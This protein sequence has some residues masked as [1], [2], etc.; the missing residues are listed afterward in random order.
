MEELKFVSTD[1]VGDNVALL[2]RGNKFKFIK[3]VAIIL[4]IEAALLFSL[5]NMEK[6][7]KNIIIISILML[8]GV[9]V[10]VLMKKMLKTS[11]G[12]V[13]KHEVREYVSFSFFSDKIVGETK[14]KD[15]GEV[16]SK[17]YDY[18]LVRSFKEDATRIYLKVS[19]TAFLVVNK[20]N[21]DS[22]DIEK[23]KNLLR[24]KGI[25]VD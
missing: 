20:S 2:R 18:R 19:D 10:V 17:D 23:L 6:S 11:E 14:F 8:L 21:N 22:S 24:T 12:Y 7:A 1:C 16:V 9:G 15:T 25:R 4:V 13:A 5:I 3:T